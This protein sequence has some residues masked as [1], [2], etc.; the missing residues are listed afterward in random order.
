MTTLAWDSY[1]TPTLVAALLAVDPKGL[2]GVWVRA[3]MGPQ[4]SRIEAALAAIGLPRVPIQ[5]GV[6]QLA[7]FGGV[8]LTASLVAGQLRHREGLLSRPGAFWLHQVERMERRLSVRI[9][10]AFDGAR[11]AVLV[12]SDEGTEDDALPS[13]ALRSR[14]AFFLCEDDSL[15]AASHQFSEPALNDARVRLSSVV[16]TGISDF[17]ITGARLGIS[18]A[19]ALLFAVKAARAL[20]ALAGRDA[21]IEADHAKAAELVFRHRA[22]PVSEEENVPPPKQPEVDK[23][24]DSK[25]SADASDGT[26]IPQDMVVEA[27][28]TSLPDGLLAGLAMRA[29]LARGRGEGDTRISAH[30]GRPLPSRAGQLDGRSRIDVLATLQA[31]APWQGLRGSA[32]GG[33]IA[34]RPEDIRIRRFRETS[35]RVLIFLVDAS[36]SA[37]MARLAEAKGAAESLLA[38]AYESRDLVGL[39]VFRGS[40]AEVILPPTKSLVRAKRALSTLPAG[41]ATPLAAGLAL[42]KSLAEQ[43]RRQGQQPHVILMTDGRGNCSLSGETDRATAHRDALQ[44]ARLLAASNVPVTL[45]DSG[46]R[47]S[48]QLSE[49]A[50]TLAADIV[51]LPRFGATTGPSLAEQLTT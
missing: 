24:S 1:D 33:G 36:G 19:R 15:V 27:A 6:D 3:R 31:A 35:E 43:T 26:R 2:G 37:A 21:P 42:G 32:A 18:D 22:L 48:P 5:P 23:P 46:K 4:K 7:L 40:S 17:V 34:L 47:A 10:G 13:A 25:E 38:T 30:R 28:R 14:V 44:V 41:G 45:L 39:C 9:A 20:A 11:N 29:R 16:E 51:P 8:D 49:L 12:L 50:A